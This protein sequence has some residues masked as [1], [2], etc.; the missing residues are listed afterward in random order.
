MNDLCGIRSERRLVEEVKPN[1]AYRCFCGLGLGCAFPRIPTGR[2]LNDLVGR[3]YEGKGVTKLIR[4]RRYAPEV[5]HLLEMDRGIIA[6]VEAQHLGCEPPHGAEHGVGSD[7][8][9]ALRDDQATKIES[10]VL[11]RSASRSLGR[12]RA[13]YPLRPRQPWSI[14]LPLAREFSI[15]EM[16]ESICRYG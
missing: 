6:G 16:A 1:L 11:L 15:K 12:R 13:A 4:R 8:A 5:P 7:D 9:L 14:K 2:I 3:Q 10:G